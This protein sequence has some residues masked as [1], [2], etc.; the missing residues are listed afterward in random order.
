[1]TEKFNL[2]KTKPGETFRLRNGQVWSFIRL[3]SIS[4]RIAIGNVVDDNASLLLFIDGRFR[5]DGTNHE[6]DIVERIENECVA[7]LDDQGNPSS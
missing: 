5:M 6:M 4:K 1:M 7:G 2:E 3:G